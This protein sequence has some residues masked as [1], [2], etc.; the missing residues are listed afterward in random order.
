MA[1]ID[2]G[3]TTLTERILFDTGRLHRI[4]EVHD[5]TAEL[6]WR[7]LEKKHG[8]TISSA[9]TSCGWNGHQ[10]TILDT[11]GHADF[12]IEVEQSL[13]VLDGAVALFSAVAGVQPQSEAVWRQADRLGV[14]RIAFVN[15][16]DQPG[17]NFDRVV[18]EIGERLP[19]TPLAVQMPIGSEGDF[20]G[21]VDLVGL[22][23]WTWDKG[24]THPR[25]VAL[26]E[27]LVAL[28]I[29]RRRALVERLAEADDEAMALYLEKDD[30]IDAGILKELIRKA[31]LAGRITAVLCGSAARNIGI[32]PLLDAVV[33]YCPSPADRAE[34]EGRDLATGKAIPLAPDEQ[35][36]VVALVSKIQAS[37][38]GT[39]AFIRLYAGR[40]RRGQTLLNASTGQSE[41]VGR[42]LRMHAAEETEIEEA[43]AGDI[44]AVTGLKAARSGETLCDPARPV[45]LAGFQTPEPVIEAVIEPLVAAD[46]EKLGEAL[47]LMAREDPSLRVSVD[48]ETGET[49]LRGMGEL[50]LAIALESLMDEAGIPAR[51]GPPSVAY[52]EAITART[53]I[54]H[55]LRKQNGGSGQFARLRLAFEPVPS[56]Q[57][58]LVFENRVVGGAVPKAYL[59]AIEKALRSCLQEGGLAG[60]P[61]VG[62]KAEL[63]DGAVHEKDSS[64]LAFEIATRE[65]FRLAFP[66]AA[67][68]LLEPV[69]R[70]EI[71]TPAEAIGAIIGDLQSRRGTI[72]GS[73]EAR[74]LHEIVAHVPLANLFNYVNRLRS[75]SQGRAGFTMRLD[76]YATVPKALAEKIIEAAG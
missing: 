18:A 20:R 6:D 61:L 23:A 51:L 32:Q 37:R 73:A 43:M 68:V 62:L 48:A 4:G 52:R 11:P 14:P 69:M 15:K 65:A 19:A 38:F 42:I 17:A 47:A 44:V 41:R 2:A 76:R 35:A 8:I 45:L 5:G 56:D 75:L 49:L 22:T 60:Y 53:E 72:V 30:D 26:P 12:T 34:V 71:A 33:D 24:E 9:A 58:G 10:I 54:D 27:Q 57:H 36:R 16:M 67:P 7:A 64:A 50:H 1:H 74:G 59:P 40:L 28:A 55:M 3:K 39:L 70:V 13:R 46:R 31:T 63:L 21:V 25:A 29:G 66:Q